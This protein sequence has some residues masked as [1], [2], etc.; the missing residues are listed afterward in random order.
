MLRLLPA[1]LPLLS[2]SLLL[3][4]CTQSAATASKQAGEDLTILQATDLHYL[5]PS[6][7]DQGTM[8]QKVMANGDGKLAEYSE[9]ILNAFVDTAISTHPDALL[10]S[11]DLTFN[12]EKQSLQEVKTA[13]LKVKD[14]GIPVLVIPGNHDI[15]YPYAFSYFND[16]ASPV[17]NVSQDDF[18]DIMSV[19][20]YQDSI[21][22]DPSSFS[23]VYPLAEDVWILALDGN[24]EQDPGTISQQTL[25]WMETQLQKA[26]AQNIHVIAMTH[27]NVLKQSDLMY[28]GFVMDDYETVSALLKKYGVSLNLSGHSH[29]EHVSKEDGLTD[30]CTE[31]LALYPLQY[32][33]I[34]WSGSKGTFQYSLKSLNI[35]Q[36]ESYQRFQSLMR[37]KLTSTMQE[38]DIPAETKEKMI[39]FA[40]QA[41]IDYFTGQLDKLPSLY[42]E[43]GWQLWQ[44]YGSQT[45]WIDYLNAIKEAQ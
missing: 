23:Y 43:E 36:E 39:D 29:L 25:T 31:S 3:S 27:Q 40:L 22:K 33:Q 17:E 2:V 20:G 9:Q 5:S 6:L 7:T 11:G 16:A 14:A 8:F 18:K 34:D 26:Q 4:G 32:A 28:E 44:T 42:Q 1:A 15:D 13:L 30:A 38:M 41:N 12:G 37:T 45:F 24:T 19:F 10:L 21:A 35:L